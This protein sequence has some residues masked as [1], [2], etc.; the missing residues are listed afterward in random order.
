[1]AA[2]KL[3]EKVGFFGKEGKKKK[4]DKDKKKSVLAGPFSE[5]RKEEI[6]F[7]G[8]WSPGWTIGEPNREEESGRRER[9]KKNLVSL[10]LLCSLALKRRNKGLEE[11]NW[12]SLF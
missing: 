1:M 10:V 6:W 7:I 2:R 4:R 5:K 3:Q 9:R 12:F 11:A 8:A